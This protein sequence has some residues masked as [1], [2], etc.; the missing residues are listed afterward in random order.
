[1]LGGILLLQRLLCFIENILSQEPRIAISLN[2]LRLGYEIE[3]SLVS[4]SLKHGSNNKLWS[5][6][7][8]DG[9]ARQGMQRDP[10]LSGAI[11]SLRL[12]RQASLLDHEMSNVMSCKR[13][14]ANA[15][16]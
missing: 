13:D 11:S 3:N 4:M 15:T 10:F 7:C 8:R 9:Q 6:L 1:M 12:D 16:R 5:V 14:G 2:G